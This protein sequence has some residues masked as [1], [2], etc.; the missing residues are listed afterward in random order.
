M[1]QRTAAR[2]ANI[3]IDGVALRYRR[4][5]LGENPRPFAER[6]NISPGHLSNLET[7]YRRFVTPHTFAR[8]CDA[9]GLK[10]AER[11]ALV[12]DD[13]TGAAA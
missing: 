2:P 8:I 13:E 6:C 10:P 9:L 4:Q 3:A 1:P 12:L 5:L 11:P 7:G